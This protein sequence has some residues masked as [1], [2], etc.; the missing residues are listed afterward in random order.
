VTRSSRHL[1]VAEMFPRGIK[2]A[3]SGGAGRLPLGSRTLPPARARPAGPAAYR[4]VGLT[5][6]SGVS[7]SPVTARTYGPRSPAT[8]TH[9]PSVTALRSA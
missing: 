6:E 5:P 9:R 3:A 1:R 2:R 8:A 4:R 7:S